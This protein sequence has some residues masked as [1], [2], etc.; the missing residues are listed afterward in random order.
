[1]G[2]QEHVGIL[3]THSPFA[4]NVVQKEI[5]GFDKENGK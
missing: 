5:E 1:M 2:I 3:S 4:F